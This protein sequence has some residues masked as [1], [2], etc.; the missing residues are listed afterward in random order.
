MIRVRGG[1]GGQVSTLLPESKGRLLIP[2]I[3]KWRPDPSDPSHDE[4]FS[5]RIDKPLLR[6]DISNSQ[7]PTSNHKG[8]SCDRKVAS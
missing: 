7:Q 8:G 6:A 1:F 2:R 3:A 5:Q 4:P